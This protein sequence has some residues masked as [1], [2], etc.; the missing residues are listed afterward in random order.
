MFKPNFNI[1]YYSES[2][3][4]KMWCINTIPIPMYKII[5]R[6]QNHSISEDEAKDMLMIYF[7][8]LNAN[9]DI[10][11][12]LN[13]DVKIFNNFDQCY[14]VFK[15][16]YLESDDESGSEIY[17]PD[18]RFRLVWKLFSNVFN[19]N[20]FTSSE[21]SDE[22]KAAGLIS[23]GVR[24]KKGKHNTLIK[25]EEDEWNHLYFR[26]EN[27]ADSIEHLVS[28]LKEKEFF[29]SLLVY[30]IDE[31]IPKRK[32]TDYYSLAQELSVEF[33]KEEIKGKFYILTEKFI[34][35]QPKP[36][37]KSLKQSIKHESQEV[38]MTSQISPKNQKHEEN[39]KIIK[40][41]PANLKNSN[42]M[43]EPLIKSSV[44]A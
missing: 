3:H 19:T 10:T 25:G 4:K 8:R 38:R 37:L 31:N 40:E 21:Y 29:P 16:C 5:E 30:K 13:E 35:E 44:S 28:D 33:N 6:I 2:Y 41:E 39:Q 14:L 18:D 43:N 15:L 1:D 9:N 12:E 20:L 24:D 7:A 11:E 26:L 27:S 17:M 22:G 36:E 23:L 32:E 42:G 34:L